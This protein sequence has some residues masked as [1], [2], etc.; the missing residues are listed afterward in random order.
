MP[1]RKRVVDLFVCRGRVPPPRLPFPEPAFPADARPS[2]GH[3][4]LVFLVE[5]QVKQRA[6][7]LFAL[8][9]G[10]RLVRHAE[11]NRPRRG[12]RALEVCDHAG[13][14]RSWV[15]PVIVLADPPGELFQVGL[16]PGLFG[17]HGH[18]MLRPGCARTSIPRAPIPNAQLPASGSEA[19]T[20][21]CP[22]SGPRGSDASM[23][24]FALMLFRL[25]TFNLTM[26]SRAQTSLQL[27]RVSQPH[28]GRRTR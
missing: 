15:L 18:H 6:V 10:A 17:Q 16:E 3:G 19:E 26:P 14:G 8:H 9:I 21:G 11:R 20:A 23:A 4:V 1:S 5:Q 7:L 13:R 2:I 27:P 22:V 24:R 12:R 25:E 28:P